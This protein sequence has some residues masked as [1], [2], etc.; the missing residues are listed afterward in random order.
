M[1]SPNQARG[2]VLNVYVRCVVG[3][4]NFQLIYIVSKQ[5]VGILECKIAWL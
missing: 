4:S 2:I 1:P 3:P 5:N